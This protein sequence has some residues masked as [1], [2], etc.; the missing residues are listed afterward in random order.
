MISRHVRT[1]EKPK[2]SFRE[3]LGGNVR[4]SDFQHCRST[5]YVLDLL[6]IGSLEL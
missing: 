4:N 1:L 6:L 5:L 2:T 3:K